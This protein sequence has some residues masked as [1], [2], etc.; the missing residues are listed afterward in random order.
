MEL[1]Q[2]CGAARKT[3]VDF[4]CGARRLHLRTRRDIKRA[5]EATGIEF[6]EGEG[7][8]RREPATA[9]LNE[10]ESQP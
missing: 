10:A 6:E 7:V 8:R 5:L 4:E 1:A 9:D 3:L 2:R